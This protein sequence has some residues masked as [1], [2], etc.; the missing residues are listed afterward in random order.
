MVNP[1]MANLQKNDK[2]GI[3][4]KTQTMP[5]YPTGFS[6]IDHFNGYF[7]DAFDEDDNIVKTTPMVGLV[8]GSFITIIGKSGVAKTTAAIQMSVNMIKDFDAG[9]VQHFDLEQAMNYT[10]IKNVTQLPISVVK[11]KYILKQEKSTIEEIFEAC[12]EIWREKTQ[13]NRKVYEYE[14]GIMNE[15]NEPVKALVPTVVILDSI[16]TITTNDVSDGME[17]G[18]YAN[19]VAKAIAQFYKRMT[20]IIKEANIILIAINHI[21]QKIEINPRLKTQP[22]LLYLKMDESLPGGQWLP[23]AVK[24]GKQIF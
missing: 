17:G 3:F 24:L 12:E 13:N 7:L 18:T 20:P 1:L 5:S 21:N 16:P 2:K 8:G 19:R 15:F 11:D 4:K 6:N 14:T 23:L 10:R 22:Q 9:M